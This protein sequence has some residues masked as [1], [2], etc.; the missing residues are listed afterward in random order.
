MPILTKYEVGI[1][2]GKQEGTKDHKW[3]ARLKLNELQER[4]TDRKHIE[5]VDALIPTAQS[6]AR[7]KAHS[8]TM[9]YDLAFHSEMN[10]LKR[11][12]GLIR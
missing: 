8:H 11:E 3:K 10:R 6:F 9:Q 5:A 2:T 1:L 12:A 4:L 7:K